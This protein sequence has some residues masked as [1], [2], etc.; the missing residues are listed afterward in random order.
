MKS[1]IN[2]IT[3]NKF[4][5]VEQGIP[6]RLTYVGNEWNL[7]I[8]ENTMQNLRNGTFKSLTFSSLEALELQFPI[9]KGVATLFA[10]GC[11]IHSSAVATHH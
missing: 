3:P 2:Q 5:I 11:P 9:W 10:G 6:H 8:G 1:E 4:E 7:T